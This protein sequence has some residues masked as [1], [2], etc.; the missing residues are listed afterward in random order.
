MCATFSCRRLLAL[1]CLL[2]LSLPF[3]PT[4]ASGVVRYAAPTARGSG[5][6]SS[7]DNA[8]TLQAALDIANSGDQIWVQAGVHKPTTNPLD[9]TAAFALKNGVAIYGGFAGTESTLDE[10]NWTAYA[11]VLS[12]DI[13]NNDTTDLHSITT[14]INGANSYHVV[15]ATNVIS[16]AVL[17]GF[18]VTGGQA[19]GASPHSD[20]GGMYNIN[21]GPT[22]A[23]VTFIGN[24]AANDGGGMFNFNNSGPMLMH[25]AFISNTAGDGGGIA[26]GYNSSPMLVNVVFSGNTADNGAGMF[27]YVSSSPTMINVTF[28]GNTAL[29]TDPYAGRVIFNDNQSS[30]TLQNAIIWNNGASSI[31]SYNSSIPVIASS[32]VQG[33]GGSG[34]WQADCGIDGGGNIDADPLFVNVSARNLRLQAGS[35]A[36]DTGNNAFVPSIAMTDLDGKPRIQDGNGDSSPVV[37]MGGYEHDMTAPTVIS[38]THGSPNPTNAANVTFIIA[39]SEAVTGVDPLDFTLT[40]TGNVSGASI[41]SVRGMSG[42]NGINGSWVMYRIEVNTGSGDGTLRLD[43]SAGAI[44]IDLAEN[45]L[46]GLPY[47]SGAVYDIDKTPPT[48]TLSSSVSDPTGLASIPVTVTFSEAVT[49]FTVDDLSI[50]NGTVSN[51]AG[52]GAYY[53]FDLLPLVLGTTSVTVATNAAQDAAG[54]GNLPAAF[55]RTIIETTPPTPTPTPPSVQRVHLPLIT[56]PGQ[57]D[58]VIDRI[59]IIPDQTSFTAGQTVEIQV[60]VKN[61]GHAPAGPFWID[62]YIN[63]DRPPQINDLWHNRCTLNPCFGVAWGVAQGLQPGEQITL[64]TRSGSSALHTYWLG[65]LANGTTTIYA[66]ADSWNTVGTYG[67]VFESDESNNRGVL[68]GLNVSGNNP[69]APPWT[70]LYL[71]GASQMSLLPVRPVSEAP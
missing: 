7:W 54:N 39:F 14:T 43:I 47:T 19:N 8:C 22:L 17:D 57:P 58:L 44:I 23:H 3:A 28:G 24:V 36:I 48:I 69:P 30:P 15:I 62:L 5:D 27:N 2:L 35:P 31:V 29:N 53:T 25:T 10:R 6:C 33:C 11:T 60:T 1:V 32:N 65:W 70:P 67:A 46:A 50:V 63:P 9:R 64:S 55:T 16:T 34:A 12:G 4:R 68:D 42:V 41:S 56:S 45:A 40:A 37:D 13:D 20:G 71:F 61:I 49:G 66:L 21:G 59:T 26:N 52:S 38:M 51:F 18:I